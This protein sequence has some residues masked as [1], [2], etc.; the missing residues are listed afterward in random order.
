MHTARMKLPQRVAC[1]EQSFPLS[2]VAASLPDG[3]TGVQCEGSRTRLQ[4]R[5]KVRQFLNGTGRPELHGI[6]FQVTKYLCLCDAVSHLDTTRRPSPM[7]VE[8]NRIKRR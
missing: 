7:L 3:T 2:P 8:G 4:W 1:R 5:H 6:G